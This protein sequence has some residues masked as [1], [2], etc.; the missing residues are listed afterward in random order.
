MAEKISRLQLQ[1]GVYVYAG[2][3]SATYDT[4]PPTSYP[5]NGS[6]WT[7]TPTE[8][9]FRVHVKTPHGLETAFEAPWGNVAGVTYEQLPEPK[10]TALEKA[11]GKPAA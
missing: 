9:G 6:C 3:I 7:V 8:R 5:G 1:K 4:F 11:A 2:D 10:R